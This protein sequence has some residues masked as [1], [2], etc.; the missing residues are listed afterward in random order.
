[1]R[2]LCAHVHA[3][4]PPRARAQIIEWYAQEVGCA[5]DKKTVAMG[6][7]AEAL[8]TLQ[9]CARVRLSRTR[10]GKGEHKSAPYLAVHPFGKVPALQCD[11]GTPVFES[12]AILMYLA[13]RYGGLATP[14]QRAAAAAWVAFANATFWPAISGPN[15]G[16]ALPPL[17][18]AIEAL[19]SKQAFLAGPTFGV[20]DVAV[21]AYMFY[22]TAFFR[23]VSFTAFPAIA[24]YKAALEARP[25][26]KA[27][28]GA[29]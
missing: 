3:L 12:G 18:A 23:D 11:D 6:A 8:H 21:G 25:A 1:V 19:L 7:R 26:F 27:T 17:C 10:A 16:A 4:L 22:A 2:L 20:A 5:L 13:D 9:G 15:R 28:V 29:E 14:E 24:K